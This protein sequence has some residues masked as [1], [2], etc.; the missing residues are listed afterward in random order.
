MRTRRT[1][2]IRNEER[3]KKEGRRRKRLPST[4]SGPP[5]FVN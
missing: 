1:E 3:K 4:I 2:G 5:I